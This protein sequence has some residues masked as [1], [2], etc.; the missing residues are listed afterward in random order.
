MFMVREAD[1]R[2]HRLVF[3]PELPATVNGARIDLDT[4][5][6]RQNDLIEGFIRQHPDHWLWLHRKWKTEHPEMY[7]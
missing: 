7:R 4:L 6:Q 5:T 2:R 3:G 1:P